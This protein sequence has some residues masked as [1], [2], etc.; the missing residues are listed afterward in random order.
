MA[1]TRGASAVSLSGR[2]KTHPPSAEEWYSSKLRRVV[3]SWETA[4][5]AVGA[6]SR[7]RRTHAETAKLWNVSST[8]RPVVAWSSTPSNEI[9]RPSTP[10]VP[11]VAPP[12]SVASARWPRPMTEVA[13]A[14]S[15]RGQTSLAGRPVPT[16]SRAARA[17]TWASVSW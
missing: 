6:L 12:L 10:S 17:P 5:A 13:S 9:A 8:G 3:P 1:R 15:S 4:M 2:V 14:S 11:D 16:G 7:G